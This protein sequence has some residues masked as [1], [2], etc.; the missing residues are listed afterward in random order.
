MGMKR[1]MRKIRMTPAQA[2][3]MT[4]NPD[5][6]FCPEVDERLS[7]MIAAAMKRKIHVRYT[8]VHPARLVPHVPEAL[9]TA[10]VH[11]L[12]EPS[13]REAVLRDLLSDHPGALSVYRNDRGDLCSFDDYLLLAVALDAKVQTVRV[14]I[15]GEGTQRYKLTESPFCLRKGL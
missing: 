3:T 4:A 7:H 11:L 14:V 5:K 10:K 8:A 12:E 15:F 13:L 1:E 9:E 6:R 2:K